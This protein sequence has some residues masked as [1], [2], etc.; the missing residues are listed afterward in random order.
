VR[1]VVDPALC[2]GH[3]QCAAVAP[4]VYSLDDE[5]Y[6]TILGTEAEVPQGLEADA[7]RGAGSCPD[8]AIQTT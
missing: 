5:G 7:L 3:G 1:F 8:G 6:N 4:G 2:C